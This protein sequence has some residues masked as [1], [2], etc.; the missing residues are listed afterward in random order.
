MY[1]G[2]CV[3]SQIMAQLPASASSEI[4]PPRSCRRHFPK[5]ACESQREAR[6]AH[7]TYT[8]QI[9]A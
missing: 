4:V 5:R 9:G 2:Q 8:V 7:P 3:F 1:E 6:L